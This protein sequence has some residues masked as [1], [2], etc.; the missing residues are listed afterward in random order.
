MEQLSLR[1][2]GGRKWALASPIIVNARL[3]VGEPEGAFFL[4]E[5][6][7]QR[8]G[9]RPYVTAAGVVTVL[10]PKISSYA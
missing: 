5:E 8:N 4:L 10:A 1:R 3:G 2:Q 9:K 7:A 6:P